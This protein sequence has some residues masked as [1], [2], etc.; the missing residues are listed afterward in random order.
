MAYAPR[1]YWKHIMNKVVAAG[2]VRALLWAIGDP[3]GDIRPVME[4]DGWDF[5]LEG[6]TSATIEAISL[7]A[8]ATGAEKHRIILA[9]LDSGTPTPAMALSNVFTAGDLHSNI[10]FDVDSGTLD[11]DHA[12]MGYTG[13]DLTSE[14]YYRSYPTTNVELVSVG[15]ND[16]AITVW[17]HGNPGICRGYL[18]A[19]GWLIPSDPD[20]VEDD[21][22]AWGHSVLGGGATTSISSVFMGAA[23]ASTVGGRGLWCHATANGNSH[24]GWRNP[25][26]K[27][28]EHSNTLNLR[29]PG[30]STGSPGTHTLYDAITQTRLLLPCALFTDGTTTA[31]R[32]FVAEG[33][34]YCSNEINGHL[35]AGYDASNVLHE[36][37]VFFA[38]DL[39]SL[40][41]A[42]L[43]ETYNTNLIKPL[44]VP[45]P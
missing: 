33:C 36:Y 3:T 25:I 2:T 27:V 23:N 9:G 41:H 6:T 30:G 31:S 4:A 40:G 8:P 18:F 28:W 29:E 13:V 20:Y 12:T 7:T 17:V 42:V 43:L 32:K 38:Y 34:Y 16:H 26:S 19:G 39:S 35:S 24:F 45:E 1:S 5:E 22:R 37:A 11:W 15:Y 14:G 21:G 10:V 44:P